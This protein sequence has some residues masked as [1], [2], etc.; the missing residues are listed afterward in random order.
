M[1]FPLKSI[2]LS[3]MPGK[4]RWVPTIHSCQLCVKSSLV[5][6]PVNN[7]QLHFLVTSEQRA[8]GRDIF[9]QPE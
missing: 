3:H 6:E 9:R 8:T 2:I 4:R 5:K 1:N 7:M